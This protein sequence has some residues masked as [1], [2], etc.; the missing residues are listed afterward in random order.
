MSD[1]PTIDEV[2]RVLQLERGR[3]LAERTAEETAMR[4][5]L[6]ARVD[7]PDSVVPYLGA[8]GVAGAAMGIGILGLGLP[9]PTVSAWGLTFLGLALLFRRMDDVPPD[10]PNALLRWAG[11]R[12]ERLREKFGAEL[13]G[14]MSLTTFVQYELS[15]LSNTDLSLAEFLADPVV[16]A[17][18]WFITETIESLMNAIW[19]SLWWLPL[20][21]Q[22]WQLALAVIAAA[23]A[24]LWMLDMPVG[25][26][27]PEARPEA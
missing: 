19:A 8:T 22:G 4:E 12:V 1:E 10:H 2:E 27:D 15:S 25:D 21:S 17:V 3:E 6:P 20:F 5:N 7:E 14:V 18:T 11:S 26:T 23:W 24:V 16:V 9:V 13:Y